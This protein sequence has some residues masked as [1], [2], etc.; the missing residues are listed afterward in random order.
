MDSLR[1]AFPDLEDGLF[2]ADGGGNWD[3]LRTIEGRAAL[4]EH[5][6][7]LIELARALDAGFILDAPVFQCSGLPIG[8]AEVEAIDRRAI[9]FAAELRD[10][11]ALERRVVLGAT[12][13]PCPDWDGEWRIVGD[14]A[15]RLFV[16][17]MRW[18]ANSGIELVGGPAFSGTAR[19]A[20]F[21]E[22]AG[23]A[24]LQVAVTLEIDSAGRLA[25]GQPLRE[26]VE[27]VDACTGAH[28]AWF[29]V[30][31]ANPAHLAAALD[32]PWA[33]RVRGIEAF[34][35]PGAAL[36]PEALRRA[37]DELARKAPWIGIVQLGGGRN[38]RSAAAL[39][40]ALRT[41][42]VAACD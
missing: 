41:E 22:A 18:L 23:D 35:G 20:A 26:A 5:L 14:E 29:T 9:A 21:A 10:A 17:Q 7:G 8:T 33:Q 13:G 38:L 24:G 34:T 4:R 15:E 16:A 39:A 32:G 1:T 6:L 37:C 2:L 31:C 30:R 40:R 19:A 27:A 42:L 25:D 36:P 28:P 3:A 12:L 11:A